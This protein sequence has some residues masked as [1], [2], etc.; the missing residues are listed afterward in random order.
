[1]FK[2]VKLI[3]E[4]NASKNRLVKNNISLASR[5]KKANEEIDRL[6]LLNFE[7]SMKVLAEKEKNEKTET[8]AK[9][10]K[11]KIIHFMD[12]LRECPKELDIKLDWFQDDECVDD[13]DISV[14]TGICK[15]GGCYTG[16][17]KL[18]SMMEAYLYS[19][20]FFMIHGSISDSLCPDCYAEYRE[21]C[22]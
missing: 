10:L 6:K 9:E 22:I 16:E 1:M 17:V 2:I 15:Y 4:R 7:A 8:E 14:Y 5:L 21:A 13:C 12:I 11:K 18:K 19:E 20:M 3:K